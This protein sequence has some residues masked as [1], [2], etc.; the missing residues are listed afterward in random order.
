MGKTGVK[1]A[2]GGG[3]GGGGGGSGGKKWVVKSENETKEGADEEEPITSPLLLEQNTGPIYARDVLLKMSQ[4]V[5]KQDS[6][7]LKYSTQ[8]RPAAEEEEEP[9]GQRRSSKQRQQDKR[10]KAARKASAPEHEAAMDEAAEE[11]TAQD[12]A[13]MMPLN[14]MMDPALMQYLQLMAF[15][16]YGFTPSATCTTVMLRNIPNRYTRDMLV[17]KLAERFPGGYDFVYLPIDFNSKCN[18]GYAFI[19][20]RTPAECQRFFQEFDH[21]KTKLCLPGFSSQKVCQVSYARVQGRDAN[22]DNLRDE[23]F[24][25]KLVDRPEWQPLFLD[26]A[27]KEI[28]FESLVGPGR[29]QRSNSR[30][31]EMQQMQQLQQMQAAMMAQ[32]MLQQQQAGG[33]GKGGQQKQ[34]GVLKSSL[35]SATNNTLIVLKNIPKD[36]TSANVAES[37]NKNHVGSYD[38]VYAPKHSSKDENRGQAFV[39][40]KSTKTAQAFLKAF[41]EGGAADMFVSDAEESSAGE[42]V[43]AATAKLGQVD[44]NLNQFLGLSKKNVDS[45]GWSPL[46]VDASG[47]TSALPV[48]SPAQQQSMTQ[49]HYAAFAGQQYPGMYGYPGYYGAYGSYGGSNQTMY[50]SA[51]A[52]MIRAQQAAAT[53]QA[54]HHAQVTPLSGGKGGQKGGS[55]GASKDKQDMILNQVNYY[56]SED[57]LCKDTFLREHMDAEGWVKL[58]LI[59]GFNKMKAYSIEAATNAIANSTIVEFN[60]AKDQMRLKDEDLRRRWAGRQASDAAP[61]AGSSGGASS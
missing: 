54:Q 4:V 49:A 43:V 32:Y 60:A 8:E 18:V 48:T 6:A 42:P 21:V 22:L 40:F 53:H 10:E 59:M 13:Q 55:K 11:D 25:E 39:N 34:A 38:F 36:L 28:P 12:A 51:Q 7:D 33:Y 44:G 24:M 50:H 17:E 58:S 26:E 31:V 35:P 5:G 15:Q 9:Q 46:L 16:P 1:R 3:A 29:K 45:K 23:K 37:L 56:F 47:V 30:T 57:N 20:F 27:G 19:N 52:S 2:G 61:A 14:S 41:N